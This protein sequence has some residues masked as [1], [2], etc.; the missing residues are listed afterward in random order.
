VNKWNINNKYLR[1]N[2][3]EIQLKYGGNNIIIVNEKVVYA[4]LDFDVWC[5]FWDS[6]SLEEQEEACTTYITSVDAPTVMYNG[7]TIPRLF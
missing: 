3:E 6:L 1:Y 4:G 5:T 2:Y 7:T